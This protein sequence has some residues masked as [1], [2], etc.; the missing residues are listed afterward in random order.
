MRLSSTSWCR[1]ICNQNKTKSREKR[2]F[3]F[4]LFLFYQSTIVITAIHHTRSQL[5]GFHI[6]IHAARMWRSRKNLDPDRIWT[7]DLWI[8]SPEKKRTWNLTTLDVNIYP[9]YWLNLNGMTFCAHTVY[10]AKTILQ[11]W[12]K[13]V[14]VIIISRAPVKRDDIRT[15]GATDRREREL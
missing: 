3:S 1:R 7:R 11:W 6:S 4:K 12:L 9:L 2:A 14:P 5:P 10:I 8:Q 13:L 15:Q